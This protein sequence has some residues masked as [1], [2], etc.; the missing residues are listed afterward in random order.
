VDRS[1][2]YFRLVYSFGT[3][4][5]KEWKVLPGERI[6]IYAD[7]VAPLEWLPQA[8]E[9]VQ[10]YWQNPPGKTFASYVVPPDASEGVLTKL[11]DLTDD[12][13]GVRERDLEFY[14]ADSGANR[15]VSAQ[16]LVG[17]QTFS[18]GLTFDVLPIQS[19]LTTSGPLGTAQLNP[20]GTMMQ[21]LNPGAM[22]G[23]KFESS[24]NVPNGFADGEFA[25]VQ[26]VSPNLVDTGTDQI[27]VTHEYVSRANGKTGLDTEFPY[28]MVPTFGFPDPKKPRPTWWGKAVT[29]DS[30]GSSFTTF[31]GNVPTEMDSV[32]RDDKFEMYLM[33]KPAGQNSSWVPLKKLEWW[34]KGKAIKDAFGWTIQKGSNTQGS[35]PAL[36]VSDHP[37]WTE[38]MFPLLNQIVEKPR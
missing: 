8:P 20:Q 28:S 34:W 1:R 11:P 14:W 18:D 21:F 15:T 32:S 29:Q 19:D 31:V 27:P 37:Q 5:R 26:I 30:P 25:F 35:S 9:Q 36:N 6:A 33:F 16:V 17:G 13:P 3:P 22:P 24:V 12:I 38:N 7:L 4:D 2:V 23:I 10:Y